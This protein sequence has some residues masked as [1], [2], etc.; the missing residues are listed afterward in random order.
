M[1]KTTIGWTEETW[2]PVEDDGTRREWE[3]PGDLVEPRHV[4]AEDCRMVTR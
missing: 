4:S 2:N 1:K 3:Y